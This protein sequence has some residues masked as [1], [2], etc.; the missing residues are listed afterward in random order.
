MI[1]IRLQ[2]CERV[3]LYSDDVRASAVQSA[4]MFAIAPGEGIVISNGAEKT[5]STEAHTVAPVAKKPNMTVAEFIELS[6]RILPG[7]AEPERGTDYGSV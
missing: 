7:K 2:T 1:V 4:S 6:G 3:G 5:E